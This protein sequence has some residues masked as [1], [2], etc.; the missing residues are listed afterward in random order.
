MEGGRWGAEG[1]WAGYGEGCRWRTQHKQC[2]Q[3][4]QGLVPG[5]RWGCAGQQQHDEA[6]PCGGP[7]GNAEAVADAC[8]VAHGRWAKLLGVRQQQHARLGLTDFVDFYTLT[9]HSIAA[10]ERV[11]GRLGYSIR[12]ALQSQAKAFVDTFHATK[13]SIQ[14]STVQYSTA[15]NTSASL[16]RCL[17]PSRRLGGRSVPSSSP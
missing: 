14:Y 7:T 2:F 17:P 13:V 6:A 11:G 10:T 9:S 5:G 3:F 15:F 4:S 16:A 1:G 8:D 12:G